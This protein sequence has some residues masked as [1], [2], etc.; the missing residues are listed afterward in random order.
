MEKNS[1][2]ATGT[3]GL[4]V[5]ALALEQTGTWVQLPAS[6]RFFIFSVASILLCC[7]CKALEGPILTRVGII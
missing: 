2:P 4:V 3:G 7:H 6:V 1:G 5:I